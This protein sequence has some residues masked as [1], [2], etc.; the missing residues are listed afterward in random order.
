[1]I[2]RNNIKDIIRAAQVVREI[3]RARHEPSGVGAS[4]L[5]R[6]ALAV[7]FMYLVVIAQEMVGV[8]GLVIVVILSLVVLFLS[9]SHRK[10]NGFS[11]RNSFS[12]IAQITSS[13]SIRQSRKLDVDDRAK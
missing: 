5:V 7:G 8:I 1:M 2:L 10:V 11:E 12:H 9:V 13:H 4:V 3:D 6:A